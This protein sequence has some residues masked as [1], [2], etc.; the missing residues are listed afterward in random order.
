M[1]G[2]AAEIPQRKLRGERAA[3][4]IFCLF[5]GF[6]YVGTLLGRRA[7]WQAGRGFFLRE[8]AA[9][10]AVWTALERE[11]SVFY[12]GLELGKNVS[13]ILNELELGVAFV[14]PENFIGVGD[15]YRKCFGGGRHC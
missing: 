5:T 7:G 4:D 9:A 3:A 2:N 14:G 13:V 10:H 8:A 1:D 15:G 6:A 11:D 12:V